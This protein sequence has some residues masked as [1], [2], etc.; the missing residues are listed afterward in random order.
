MVDPPVRNSI[1]SVIFDFG[2]VL[3]R[4][5]PEEITR[6]F[7]SDHGLR[8][9]LKHAVFQHPDWIDMDRG[10]LSEDLAAE[11]FA[12]RMGRPPEE[13]RQLLERVRDSLTPIGESFAIVKSLAMQ[14]IP[15]YA[16]SNMPASTFSYLRDRYD[17]WGV[18]EGIVISGEIGMIKPEPDIF[19]YIARRY[20]LV[21]SETIFVD[22]HLSN[23]ES[24]ARLGFRTIHFSTPQ[25]CAAEF[26]SLL[27]VGQ[28]HRP[29]R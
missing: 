7:Y 15:L 18:F 8:D 4:W 11:R 28:P 2:G 26:H 24:G 29:A 12:A 10:T 5:R 21:P 22:D 14:G 9:A 19:D 6:D 16:L 27:G 3:L 20:D 25:Q 1:R 17:C 23:V 13:M